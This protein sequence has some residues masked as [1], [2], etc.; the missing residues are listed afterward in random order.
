[1]VRKIIFICEILYH[2]FNTV[3]EIISAAEEIVKR[4]REYTDECD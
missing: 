4:W 2:I 1:M 3:R